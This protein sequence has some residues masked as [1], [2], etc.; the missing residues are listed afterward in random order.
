MEKYLE[1]LD[2][3]ITRLG[4]T[5]VVP[6][7]LNPKTHLDQFETYEAFFQK[8]ANAA[9]EHAGPVHAPN[10][11]MAFLF[12][13]EQY[14]RRFTC[15]G[16]FVI[17]TDAI[18]ATPFGDNDKNIYDQ[19]VPRGE[20][21]L[22]GP[23]RKFEIFHLKKRGIH[24]VHVGTVE[25]RSHEEAIFKAKEHFGELSP[26]VNIWVAA[27]EDIRFSS[28]EE[29]DFWDTLPLKKYREAMAY[30]VQDRIDR[31]KQAHSN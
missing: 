16:L 14:S 7:Q 26:V 4:I 8:R 23:V 21:D 19:I 2:P 3:R 13:K 20:I 18:Q 12:G 27:A 30:R 28:P 1:S 9:Y 5:E 25:A 22:S 11:E 24:H 31:Y 17:R 29:K 10:V 6:E 15:T